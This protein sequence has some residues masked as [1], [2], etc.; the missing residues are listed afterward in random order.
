MANVVDKGLS[1]L[2]LRLSYGAL[3]NNSVG[4]Y[5]AIST[6]ATSNYTVGNTLAL[7]MA[8]IALANAGLTW[9]TTYVTNVGVDFGFFNNRLTGTFDYFHKRTKDILIDLLTLS[10]TEQL[11]SPSRTVRRL[12]TKVSNSLWDGRIKWEIS[13]TE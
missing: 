3:G 2:K 11:Q 5:D 8:Q 9:E 7:G 1:N 13:L 12:Q 10:F 6:Y 4:N